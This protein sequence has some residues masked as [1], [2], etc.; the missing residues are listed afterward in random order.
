MKVGEA[1]KEVWKVGEAV[2][3]GGEEGVEGR[4]GGGGG[5]GGSGPWSFRWSQL[6]DREA[7][8][9]GS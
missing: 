4:K 2:G 8:G 6:R 1:D 7:A 5:G 9:G 3:E